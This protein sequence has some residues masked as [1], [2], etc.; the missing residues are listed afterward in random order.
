MPPPSHTPRS[1]C[2]ATSSPIAAGRDG[3]ARNSPICISIPRKFPVFF[4]SLHLLFF[5]LGAALLLGLASCAQPDLSQQMHLAV[6]AAAQQQYTEAAKYAETCLE[7]APDMPEAI[8]LSNYCHFLMENRESA[9]KQALYNLSKLTKSAPDRYDTWLFYG[10][11][12]VENNQLRDAIDPLER[13]YK[14]VPAKDPNRP[15]IQMLLGRCYVNNNLQKQALGILQPLQIKAPYSQW[16]ELYN[17]LGI[18]ALQRQNAKLAVTFFQHG[19]SLDSR[20]EVLLQ[21]LAVT[22]DLYLND[23]ANARKYYIACLVQKQAANDTESCR[24]ITARLRKLNKR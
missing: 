4:R 15:R 8:L 5:A 10:W 13:A 9:R 1:S 3:P 7:Y 12:L 20:N 14:L 16:P 11:A 19:L 24:R 18:L 2:K 17:C 6:E 22:H 21:N 23:T